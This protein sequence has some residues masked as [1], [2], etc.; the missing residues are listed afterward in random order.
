MRN[1]LLALLFACVT[2]AGCVEATVDPFSAKTRDMIESNNRQ[3]ENIQ[4]VQDGLITAAAEVD[5]KVTGMELNA[6]TLEAKLADIKVE[7]AAIR[8]SVAHDIENLNGKLNS[9]AFSGGGPYVTAVAIVLIVCGVAAPV[10]LIWLLVRSKKGWRAF[11][12]LRGALKAS[13]QSDG[14]LNP[15]TIKQVYKDKINGS[16]EKNL[17]IDDLFDMS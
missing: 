17:E 8:S 9:G 6:E 12:A 15:N 4:T 11:D 14:P 2:L 16:I 10:V 13:A 5:A 7:A 3:M 1:A